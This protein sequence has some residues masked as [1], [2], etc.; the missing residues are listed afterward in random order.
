MQSV[1]RSRI[2]SK[3]Y[4]ASQKKKRLY[5]ILVFIYTSIK[6]KSKRGRKKNIRQDS[7]GSFHRQNS[8]IKVFIMNRNMIFKNN[9]IFNLGEVV[10][11]ITANITTDKM[12]CNTFHISPNTPQISPPKMILHKVFHLLS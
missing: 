4:F 8:Q 3:N 5:F 2:I 1:P 7:L 6:V 9:I 10:S 11:E 12:R